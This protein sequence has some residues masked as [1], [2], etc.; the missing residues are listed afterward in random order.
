MPHPVRSLR[1][2]QR[3]TLA[4]EQLGPSFVKLGQALSTRPD[5]IGESIAT[6]LSELQD[7]LSPFDGKIAIQIIEQ[8]LGQS[9]H[10]LYRSFDEKAVAAAS[11]AQVHFAVTLEDKEVAVKILRPSV[12]RLFAKDISL[13]FSLARF[14]DR[15]FPSLR[16]LKLVEVLDTL[17]EMIKFEMDL[18]LEAAAASE[19]RDNF[20]DDPNFLIP[21]IDWQRTAKRVLTLERMK[22]I[23]ID[24]VDQLLE[25]GHNIDRLV[26]NAASIFFNMVFRDGFFHADLHPG[27][28]FVAASGELIAVDFGITGRLDQKTRLF[29]GEMLL[30]FLK[31]NYRRVAEIHFEMGF[32]PKNHSIDSF[33]QACRAIAEPILDKPLHEISAAKLLGQL[34]AITETFNME[35][36]PQLLLLQKSMLVI[37]GVGRKLAPQTNMWELSRPLIEEW[38]AKNLNPIT[39]TKN[40]IDNFSRIFEQFPQLMERGIEI[41]S[42]LHHSGLLLPGGRSPQKK[43]FFVTLIPWG[44]IIILIVYCLHLKS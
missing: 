23:P 17:A 16:R 5:L 20:R 11:I 6:D 24:E 43:S 44:I 18:R 33:M 30:G 39:R 42:L 1:L 36:Q 2:G 19:M 32:V 7:R 22:G 8:E 27:N 9:I 28:L 26:T 29:I 41:M 3:L 15:L 14:I 10:S 34:F 37:E 13:F 12:E 4:F 25:A 21:V 35:T 40:R 38:I 31:G